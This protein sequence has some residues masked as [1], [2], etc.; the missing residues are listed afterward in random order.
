MARNAH[1]FAIICEHTFQTLKFVGLQILQYKTVALA[2]RLDSRRVPLKFWRLP[3][4]ADFRTFLELHARALHMVQKEKVS[5]TR[6]FRYNSHPPMKVSV[7]NRRFNTIHSILST[8]HRQPKTHFF[9]CSYLVLAERPISAEEFETLQIL[10]VIT[11]SQSSDNSLL[12]FEIS[13]KIL[14]DAILLRG[15]LS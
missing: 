8:Q 7:W 5:T 14:L 4:E 11:H 15:D 10:D 12:N 13:P 3:I 2:K 6:N 9:G 1:L